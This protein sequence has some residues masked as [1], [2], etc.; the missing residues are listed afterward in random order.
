MYK[1]SLLLCLI[2]LLVG[3]S[4]SSESENNIKASC[5]VEAHEAG[6]VA[7]CFE[8]DLDFVKSRCA[9][10][11]SVT[12]SIDKGCPRDRGY[13]GHCVRDDGEYIPF[14]YDSPSVLAQYT[15]QQLKWNEEIVR[16]GSEKDCIDS[17]GKWYRQ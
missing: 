12:F 9:T 16:K 7:I 4:S 17:G 11:S 2:V 15:E 8:G 10:G 1:T 3:C 13:Y 14:S 5:L 6:E